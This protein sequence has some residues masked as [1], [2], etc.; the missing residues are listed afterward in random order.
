MFPFDDVTMVTPMYYENGRLLYVFQEDIKN[1]YVGRMINYLFFTIS[2]IKT[3]IALI[4]A[5]I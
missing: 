5:L 2:F 4:T 1:A 3:M